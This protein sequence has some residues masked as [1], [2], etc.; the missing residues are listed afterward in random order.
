[1]F[2][3]LT[4]AFSKARKPVVVERAKH[5]IS[6]KNID[7]DALKTLYRLSHFGYTAYLV[8]GGVRD[9]LLGR[10]PKDF[11]VA[12]NATPREVK[13]VFRNC[14]LIGRRFRLAHVKYGDKV[15]ET[16]TFRSN[17]QTVGEIIEHAA[18]GPFED[19]TWGTPETDAFRRDFTVNGLFYDI[20]T[21]A[22][23]DYVG[24][25]YDLERKL[26]RSIGDPMIRFRE[27]PVR[28]MRAIRFACK[29]G[30]TIEKGTSKAMQKLHSCILSA[31]IP[32]LCEEIYRFFGNGTS[33]K[34]F[35]M[36][37]KCGMLGD[38]L[39]ELAAFI[40]MDGGARAELFKNLEALDAYEKEI[41]S[42][43]RE[44]TNAVRT[45]VMLQPLAKA[46]SSVDA[47]RTMGRFKVPKV[48][49]FGAIA[50]MDSVK[51]FRQR[52]GKNAR[53]YLLREEAQDYL[54]FNRI[55]CRANGEKT[56]ALEAW[57][58]LYRQL[59]QPK[60]SAGA[61][62]NPAAPGEGAPASA[63]NAQDETRPPR[64]RRGGGRFRRKFNDFPR[65]EEDA[66]QQT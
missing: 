37:W 39:P 17:S 51:T 13:R 19:N 11:D 55:A 27:D 42:S 58:D 5:C 7:P 52:P 56:D 57:E 60:T 1:M 9:L 49:H 61:S 46:T 21:F 63:A 18:E 41:K 62:Q 31:S 64:R 22:V 28:M 26:I 48:V 30:F 54:D 8:G 15:I 20:N 4:K 53:R 47:V 45:A 24:G 29:L 50:L 23:I 35:E 32:R 14:F 12:T 25:M 66:G 43:G 10:T 44:L 38:L 59:A 6:R 36:M 16:A 40:E 34:A 33:A 65:P 2:E 3:F